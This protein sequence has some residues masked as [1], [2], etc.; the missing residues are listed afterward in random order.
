V[1]VP[2]VVC[3]G[4]QPSFNR[5]IA[6]SLWLV[7]VAPVEGDDAK[8]TLAKTEAAK[9]VATLTG[10]ESELLFVV[11][12]AEGVPVAL[13]ATPRAYDAAVLDLPTPV[14]PPPPGPPTEGDDPA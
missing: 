12:Y 2:F 5:P 7:S 6:A 8:Q 14:E 4:F 13:T 1:S 9:I 11:A 3:Q 10:I